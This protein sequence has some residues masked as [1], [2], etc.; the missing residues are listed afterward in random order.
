MAPS[1]AVIFGCA[2]LELSPEEVAFFTKTQP[3]G[4]ILF[5]RNCDTPKQV[6]D[7]TQQLRDC[8]QSKDALILIDQEGGRVCRLKP[9]HWRHP[10]AAQVFAQLAERDLG[11]ACEA[12]TLNVRLIGQELREL[13]INVDCLPVLDIPEEGADSVIGDRAYG[14]DVDQIAAL[15]RTACSALMHEGILPVIKHIPGHG[16]ATVDSHKALPIVDTEHAE[17]SQIDFMPFKVL[18]DMPLAMTAHVIY[19][20][21]D[22]DHPAT[23]SKRVVKEI[24]RDEICFDGLLMTDDL[25][26]QA[27]AG[28]FAER[29]RTSLEAGCDVV[30]HCNGEMSEMVEIATAVYDMTDEANERL[31]H[32]L[33]R[34]QH[35][36][37]I[38]KEASLAR[39][40]ELLE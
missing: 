28:S 38:D 9:P 27:L 4:F 14:R 39:L 12:L 10:P 25:S 7:L 35:Y 3:I 24:L 1:K 26:M 29:T 13:G 37:T 32:A 17:L 8:I 15:G 33:A 22:A 31:A 11:L 20:A 19:S 30:L 36:E 2:G 21:I 23:T 16:R 40:E 18:A 5:A 6:Q 34:I